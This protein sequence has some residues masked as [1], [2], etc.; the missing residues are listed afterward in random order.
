MINVALDEMQK[1]AAIIEKV[2][3]NVFVEA[4]AG[5]GKTTLIVQR[6]LN[7]LKSGKLHAEQIVVI[8][9]TNKAAEEL[10]SRIEG[11]LR[12]QAKDD[13]NSE[14]ERQHLQKALRDIANMNI[15]TI[16]SFCHRLLLEHSFE[17]KLPLDVQLLEEKEAAE[18]KREWF[19]QWFATLSEDKMKE[20]K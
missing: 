7:Q 10:Y 5:A 1:R 13:A 8:T 6:I 20:L 12:R 19:D 15:S 4:G 16:H 3:D 14:E 17:A 11:T 9:F 18:W 2:E